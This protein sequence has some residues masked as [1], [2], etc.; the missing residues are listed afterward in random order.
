MVEEQKKAY[1]VK[2]KTLDVLPEAHATMAKVQVVILLF[3]FVS[4]I[5]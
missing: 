1:Q 2:K 4:V 3:C 5:F